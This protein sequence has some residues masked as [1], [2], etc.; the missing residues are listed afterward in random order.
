MPQALSLLHLRV[1]DER[2]LSAQ[3]IAGLL[4]LQK[5]Q[6]FAKHFLK[7]VG[8]KRKAMSSHMFRQLHAAAAR[9]E[10][11]RTGP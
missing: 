3:E 8:L 4:E 2:P 1:A 10:E 7:R 11:R 6:F 5:Q 9:E